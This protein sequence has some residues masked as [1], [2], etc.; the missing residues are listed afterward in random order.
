MIVTLEEL[1]KVYGISVSTDEQLTAF[2]ETAEAAVLSYAGLSEGEVSEHF[3][4]SSMLFLTYTPIK[5]ILSVTAEGN[6]I[7][8]RFEKRGHSIIL[9]HTVS[10]AVVTYSCGFD[11]YPADIKAAI[12]LTVQHL[13]KL[14]NA[15]LMGVLSR[16]T[17]GGTESIEQAIPPIAV[18]GLLDRYRIPGL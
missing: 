15:K 16:S 7:A 5:K 6:N 3:T 10:K 1:R 2:A 8:Y 9:D 13:A 17:D 11:K 18:K 4:D 12:A 14:Q